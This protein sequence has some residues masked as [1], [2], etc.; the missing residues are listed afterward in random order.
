M[1]H[2]QWAARLFVLSGRLAFCLPQQAV[3]IPKNAAA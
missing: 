3:C 1:E 2:N